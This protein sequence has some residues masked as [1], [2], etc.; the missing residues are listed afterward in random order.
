MT[1]IQPRP[2]SSSPVKG[3][4]SLA[5]RVPGGSRSFH[6]IVTR[7]I[8]PL[9]LQIPRD[10]GLYLLPL[11]ILALAIL[12]W[13]YLSVRRVVTVSLD[14]RP[15]ALWTSQS[16]VRGALV[17]AGLKWNPEDVITPG[18]DE[19]IPSDGQMRIRVAVPIVVEAD[20]THFERR[21]QATTVMGV[22]HELGIELKA[23]DRILLDGASV[24]PMYALPRATAAARTPA[25]LSNSSSRAHITVERAVPIA[26]NDN[27][28]TSTIYTTDRTLGEALRNSGV[29]VYLG[30]YVSPDLGS[31]VSSGSSVFIRRSRSASITVDGKTIKTRTREG[32][33]ASLLAQEGVQLE[34]KDYA[35]PSPTSPVLEGI[36][37]NVTRVREVYITETQYITYQ[38]RWVA[39][40]D[41]E[42]DNIVLAQ[43]GDRGIKNRL[44]KSVYENGKLISRGLVREWIA[45]PPTD[46][47][48]NYGTKVVLRDITLPDGTVTKYWRHLRMYATGYSAA[49]SGKA[50]NHPE[51]GITFT[52][53]RSGRGIVAVDPRVVNLRSKLYV[54]GYGVSI[55]GDTG[56]GIKGMRID[57]GFADG[58]IDWSVAWVD[59]YLLAPAPSARLINY[60]LPDYPREKS[61]NQ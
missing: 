58:E 12:G 46:K 26:V 39:N 5:A 33:V 29:L 16:T 18:L 55:A 14:G 7:R 11:L 6:A 53:M 34:G 51:Y 35:D 41:L 57:L 44:F 4:E 36:A 19:A 54:V 21:T 10:S 37:V 48:W 52:G 60:M 50:P 27:G 61:R 45:N 8:H 49:T 17:E 25:S 31:P 23:Q 42:L 20:G 56:G 43:P 9:V 32:N 1:P 24:D 13:S 22:L 15:L 38:V 47:I 30:D 28:L 59:V 3:H 2:V 40:P